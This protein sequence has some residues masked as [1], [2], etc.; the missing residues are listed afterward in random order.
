MSGAARSRNR[1]V[2][3]SA[4]DTIGGKMQ[5]LV[6]TEENQLAECEATIKAGLATFIDVGN[7]L[8]RIRDGKLYRVGFKT[9]EAYCADKWG[10]SRSYA[11][12]LMDASESAALL[13]I[14]NKPTAPSQVRPLAGL[15]PE[16][17][18][19][20]WMSATEKAEEGSR[21]VTAKDVEMAKAE[22]VDDA[23]IRITA[24]DKAEK[25]KFILS[26][27]SGTHKDKIEALQAVVAWC[28][29]EIRRMK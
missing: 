1:S 18:R 17:Q 24:M 23:P 11:H 3:Q 21:R 26:A 6:K 4:N 16:E 20:V 5:L 8:A 12:R 15:E 27:M 10:M 14:G 2:A 9:F 29:N 22:I 28:R 13:P 25:A 7:A 19:D